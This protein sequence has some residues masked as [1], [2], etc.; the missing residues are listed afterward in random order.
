MLLCL[1]AWPRCAAAQTFDQLRIDVEGNTIGPDGG[2]RPNVF[3]SSGPIVIGKT[4]SAGFAKLPDMCGFWGGPTLRPGAESGWSVDVTPRKVDGDAVTFRVRWVRSRHEGKDSSSP[5]GDLEWTMRPGESLPLDSLP[6]AATA[7]MPS[8]R[9]QVRAMSIR[10]AVSH[11]PRTEDDRRLVVTDLWLI[12]RQP[13]GA[14]RSQAL[15]VRGLFNHPTQFYFDTVTDGGVSL[16]LFGEFRVA[17]DGSSMVMKLETR[18]RL[19]QN[20]RSSTILR[21]GA[22]MRARQVE[23]VI[24]LKPGEVVAVE[25]PRLSENDSGAFANRTFSIRVQ[26][27]Q[28]R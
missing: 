7:T 6:L 1:L 9:C 23:S 24:Q 11:W 28:L 16:D 21:D 2:E 19:T 13:G 3:V 27:R 25:L 4:T 10:V 20:G 15:S 22:M 17:P 26:S 8:E 14:E 12:D 18:S 5:A